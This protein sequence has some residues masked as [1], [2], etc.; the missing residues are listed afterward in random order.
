MKI[1]DDSPT[2]P[3]NAYDAIVSAIRDAEGL[4]GDVEDIVDKL[5]GQQPRPAQS[6]STKRSESTGGMFGELEKR[7]LEL[8]A[9]VEQARYALHQLNNQLP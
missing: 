7:A 6:G 3:S 2:R 8:S 9:T 1:L 5:C 4:A